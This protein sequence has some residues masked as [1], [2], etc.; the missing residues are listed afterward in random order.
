M[1]RK[2]LF[3]AVCFAVFVAAL[4][5]QTTQNLKNQP[6]DGAG[7]GFQLTDGTVLYQ[8]N[9]ESDWWKLTPDDTGSYVNGTW[10]QDGELA[11]RICAGCV[12]VRGARRRPLVITGGEYLNG[13]FTL[14]NLG[15]IY[16][17]AENTWTNLACLRPVGNIIGDSPSVVLPN[18]ITWWG[19]S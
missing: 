11:C 8:G 18:G 17:P 16:D 15:A 9:G 5:S 14:T 2:I 10:A 12:C 19:T 6:P 1:P 13:N 4:F 3:V 7:I